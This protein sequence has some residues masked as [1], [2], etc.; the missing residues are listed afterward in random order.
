MVDQ[1]K[2]LMIG[3]FVIAAVTIIILVLL[4]LHPSPGDE[5]KRL[6]VRFAN[7]DKINVGTRV[8]FG[9]KPVGEVKEIRELPDAINQ[10]L[11]YNGFVYVYELDLQVNSDVN[12]FNTD[13][14][15]ARTS[16]LLGEKSIGITPHAPMPGQQLVDVSD[17]VIYAAE[18]ATVEET[19]KEFK[20][21]S[22]KIELALDLVSDHLIDLRKQDLWAKL[23]KI[24]DNVVSI[25]SSLNKP[26]E[27]A[28]TIE[29]FADLSAMAVDSWET[30]DTSVN[31]LSD[32]IV[33]VK[34]GKG[35]VG[36]ILVK[37][38]IYLKLNALLNKADTVLND[39]NHY[40]LLYH[41][42]RGWQR[43]RSRRLNLLGE[44]K[45][46]QEFRNFFNDEIDQISTSISRVSMLLE[47]DSGF[48]SCEELID[49]C[50]FVK[51]YA[52]LLRRVESLQESVKMYNQQ[53]TD[54]GTCRTELAAPCPG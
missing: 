38:D 49:N 19:L 28:S 25:T 14:I 43:L 45:T 46:P 40:G 50:E 51:V 12:V 29:N 30:I 20:E 26:D 27:L 18:T 23:G 34:A 48:T 11:E 17:R 33:D 7:I 35:T 3:L 16:G 41:S 53:V 4:F 32:V 31:N 54:C 8:T 37:D 13:E 5:G 52:E 44:L 36:S 47:N 21:L 2:N 10:R 1:L 22:D 9:G 42:D 15:S 6:R 39:I 24:G